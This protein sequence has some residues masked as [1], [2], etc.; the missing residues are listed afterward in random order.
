[1]RRHSLAKLMPVA[2]VL[3]VVATWT[4]VAGAQDADDLKRGVARISIMNGDVNVQRGDSGDWVA[5]VVNAPLI[6]GD[7]VGTGPASRA[8][9]E[10]DAANALRIGANAEVHIADLQYSRYQLEMARGVATFRILRPSEVNIEI[11]TPSVSV[12]PSRQGSVRIA[13]TE[14]GD[15]EVT[16]RG[17]DVEVFTPRGSQWIRSGQ[18][19]LARGSASDPEFQIVAAAA[20]DDWDRWCDSRDHLVQQSQSSRYVGP[21]VYGTED[22]DNYGTWQSVPEYGY[23][24]QPTVAADWS[25]YYYGRWSWVDWYG[26]TWLSSDPWGWA[27]YHY[28]RWFHHAHYGWC[29]YPGVVTARHYWS[30]ALVAF[31]GFGGG[32]GIGFGFGNVGWVP[33]AP[34]EVYHPWWGRG[35]YGSGAYINHHV[36]V[37]NVNVYNTYRNARYNSIAAV[38]YHD[39]TDGHFNRVARYNGAQIRDAGAIH[40]ATP[41]TPGSQHLRYSD[42]P[43]ANVPR[44]NENA[45]FMRAQTP[46]P[47]QR[48]SFQQQFARGGA[49]SAAGGGS[50][51]P[52]AAGQPQNSWRRFGQT[53]GSEVGSPGAGRVERG[54]F[55]S[56]GPGTSPQPADRGGWQRFGQT[57]RGGSGSA[58]QPLD[59]R[60]TPQETPQ[61]Q[62]GW[63]RFGSPGSSQPAAPR[64]ESTPGRSFGYRGNDSTPQASPRQQYQ[65]NP[66]SGR[67]FG[68]GGGRP[69]SLRVTP[70]VVR[71]RPSFSAPRQSAPSYSAPRSAPSASRS[72][73]SGGGGGGRSSGGGGGGG[74]PSGGGGGHRR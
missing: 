32:G 48:M 8:E 67:Q 70:P 14:S 64:S 72:A 39:F 28:G 17:G 45:R 35:W 22:L 13:V 44:V 27:P 68:G 10:F 65:S 41:F 12:R 16:A 51:A 36:N 31:F 40:G 23:V 19:M 24:W 60:S 33:L 38:G 56:A 47:P 53:S 25:P 62:G 49:G 59:R 71:E 37:V 15:T 46:N 63:Q 6:T 54:G 55:G 58:G 61:Q 73:P 7:R 3:L 18:S 50:S 1:M 26:W 11:D 69:E 43:A 4:G 9:I 74:R 52:A 42:R 2:E 21:G 5:G 57:N 34:Y 20:P 30:P 66:G 29:W